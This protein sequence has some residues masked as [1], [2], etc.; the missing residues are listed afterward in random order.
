MKPFIEPRPHID[1]FEAIGKKYDRELASLENEFP[2][3]LWK[4]LVAHLDGLEDEFSALATHLQ[5]VK[6]RL[7]KLR[8]AKKEKLQSK[9]S[10]SSK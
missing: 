10:S 6:P 5:Y 3:W 2:R 4:A 1:N 8:I 9:L 7:E